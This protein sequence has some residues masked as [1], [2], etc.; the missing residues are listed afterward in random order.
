MGAG[1]TITAIIPAYNCGAY[2]ADAIRSVL[3]QTE[4]VHE[5][6]VVDDGSTDDTSQVAQ[7]FAGKLTYIRTAN[8][9]AA[10][11]RNTALAR[12]TGNWV[13]FLDA[14]DTWYPT[15]IA[16]QRQVI[17]GD[18]SL[19]AVCSD[20]SL[21]DEDGSIRE[22]RY[23][24][25]K[26]RVFGAY[27]LDWPSIFPRRHRLP[28]DGPM[29]Y[30]GDGFAALYRGN[31]VNTSSILLRKA[32]LDTIGGFRNGRRTQED[33]EAWLKLAL[34]GPF[35][36]IDEPLLTFR[37]RPNQLT[38][39]TQSFRV[40]EDTAAVVSLLAPD[41]RS[42][43]EAAVVDQ[44]VAEM[45]RL[46]ALAHIGA[47]QPAAARRSLAEARAHGGLDLPTALLYLWSFTP[48]SLAV[49]LRRGLRMVKPRPVHR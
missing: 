33:Y 49:A 3:N 17:L 48:A 46:L 35:A 47:K 13:A 38:S 29:V 2:L 31:F 32:A 14:D 1:V 18:P 23:I 27:G 22:E 40:V 6:I 30:S 28:D 15:K 5:L 10:A 16:R 37:R 21:V 11:A 42:R 12:A 39:N 45:Y 36:Y 41:A 7:Q 8:A 20:F 43:M 19:L 25:R 24:T 44:R 26:Y 34:M 9:G 4:P